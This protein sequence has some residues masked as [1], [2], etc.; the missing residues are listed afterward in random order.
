VREAAQRRWVAVA[1]GLA[2]GILAAAPAVTGQIIPSTRAVNLPSWWSQTGAW[3]GQQHGDGRALVVPGAAAPVYLW[4]SPVDDALQPVADGP[5]TVRD[6]TPLAQPGYIRLLDEIE[7][8]FATGQ[9]DT[10]LAAVLARSGIRYVVV[11]NDIDPAA[12]NTVSPLFVT[13]TL[14][15]SPG[16]HLVAHFGAGT[17]TNDP[18]RITDLGATNLPGAVTIFDDTAW[19]GAVTVDAASNVVHAN[20]SAE[21]LPALVAAGVQPDQPVEFGGATTGRGGLSILD[22][23]LRR[24]EFG[25]GGIDSYSATMT[26][27]Q[28]YRTVRPIHD[29]LPSPA[30]AMS[31]DAYVG[32]ANISASS[33]GADATALINRSSANGPFAAMDG[34]A[35]T[36]WRPGVVSGGVNQ[37]W[38]V[39]LDKPVSLDSVS[40]AFVGSAGDVP[41]RVRVQTS[42]GSRVDDVGPDEL[43]QPLQLPPGPATYVRVTILHVENGSTGN[44]AGIA[45]LSIPGVSATRTLDVVGP[46]SPDLMTFSVA[47]GQRSECLTVRG[48]AA[49]NPAWL[50]A[51]EET[52]SLDRSFDLSAAGTYSDKA[53]VRLQPVAAVDTLLDAHSPV[54]AIA[55]S[56]DSSD[57][58]ERPGAA[59]D[60]NPATGW[61][62]AG[63][64]TDPDLRLSVKHRVRLSGFV[65]TPITGAPTGRPVT[66]LIGVNGQLI[67]RHVPADG[68][69]RLP[70]P[71]TTKVLSIEV[72]R[73]TARV[74]TSTA[75]GKQRFLPVGIGEVTL[76]GARVPSVTAARSL[77]IG[78]RVGP[79]MVVDGI[80]VTMS[81]HG[82]MRQAL[83]GLPLTATP[84]GNG[85][86]LLQLRSG[87]NRVSMASNALVRP[88]SI[89]LLNQQ[90]SLTTL[91]ALTPTAAS[92]SSAPRVLRWSATDRS[93]AVAT[94]VP[95]LLVV[96][97]NQNAG[98]RA[99]VNGR[100]LTAT[101][102]DGWQQAW[103]LPAGTRGVVH[104]VYTPQRI[105]TAGLIA[106]GLAA[107]LL[108]GMAFWRRSS[109]G[110]ALPALRDGSVSGPV[111]AVIVATIMLL[112][113][114]GVGL[115]LAVVALLASRFAGRSGRW[116][117]WVTAAALALVA[118]AEFIEPVSSSHP[119]A[120]SIGV[121]ALCLLAI[122]LV[123][124][125]AVVTPR[126]SPRLREPT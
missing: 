46:A 29:Y 84:C 104:L 96:H 9:R 123:L 121:Q 107:L 16:F 37:W 85:R 69:V 7:T 126:P 102:V 35:F 59:V 41:D 19:T 68:V 81:V 80:P 117:M 38:Q 43:P 86:R 78:C 51:G 45:E 18:N 120:N 64:D 57:P 11:R 114:S 62:P 33:S 110:A 34:N 91:A 101:T 77:R 83:Q 63:G 32:V 53:T 106:G 60:G 42:S 70:R 4:G 58:R 12:S 76:Q 71:V 20:G 40:V 87:A 116:A 124:A 75:N 30:P 28:P 92:T 23:G 98:W 52:N 113:G 88:Q 54:S 27:G 22:D 26:A 89:Q 119:L 105:V 31:T 109:R 39:S 111:A 50:M 115:G 72:T 36:A 67:R 125:D 24:R 90:N 112:L 100:R 5:W 97:E 1:A 94:T 79:V 8:R 118:L 3:L 122:A 2:V 99:T 17:P 47:D 49:C 15:D 82:P 95:S 93:V 6:S 61:V 21:E 74:S 48:A 10:T 13:Q 14:R 66:I 73:S 56:V 44:T 25:F 65:L 103:L 55:S 108:L